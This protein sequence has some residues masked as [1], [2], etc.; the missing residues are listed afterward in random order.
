MT[1]FTKGIFLK[2]RSGFKMIVKWIKKEFLNLHL[3]VTPEMK[4]QSMTRTMELTDLSK[5]EK[6]DEHSI[7][8]EWQ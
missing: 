5:A 6:F 1:T 2:L 3:L 8:L 4:L 7:L